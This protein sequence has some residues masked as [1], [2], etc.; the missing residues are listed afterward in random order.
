MK[1]RSLI[2]LCTLLLPLFLTA[3]YRVI[4]SE[5]LYDTPVR[6][7]G[8]Y[9]YRHNGEFVG[10]F[11]Y[12]SDPVNV[13]GWRLVG[14]PGQTFTFPQGSIMQPRA[15][16]FV[17]YR[18]RYRPNFRLEDMF[19]NFRPGTNDIVFYMDSIRLPN[20]GGGVRLFRADGAMQDSIRYHGS[21]QTNESPRLQAHNGVMP[22]RA[23]VSL[24]RR[25]VTVGE[26]GTIAFSPLDWGTYVAALD[27]YPTFVLT[28]NG[29]PVFRVAFAHDASGNRIGRRT[30]VLPSFQAAP[31]ALQ[32]PRRTGAAPAEAAYIETEHDEKEVF[33]NV[34]ADTL[35]PLE[36]VESLVSFY[37]DR[38]FEM[39][40]NNEFLDNFYTDRLNES[41]VV[42]FPNPTRGALAVEIRNM[43]P[44]I[45][46][47]ITVFALNG[48]VIFRKND[49]GS[50]TE[51]DLSSQPRGTYLLRISSQDTSI[52]WR[53]IKK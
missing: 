16:F 33:H 22:S 36:D 27:Q 52:T 42:I 46:H 2:F 31:L 45:P 12:G 34:Y 43:N 28:E 6:N 7:E 44:N 26:T 49:I 39:P 51:I 8:G 48:S 23:Y 4:I 13:S 18:A 5:V 14:G 32:G 30:I 11:N 29:V 38:L 3:Q 50:F 25:N 1:K 19:E 37:E 20:G 21:G 47:Q 9:P 17:A 41:D 40:E 15:R 24:Q 53:I 35:E 10:L